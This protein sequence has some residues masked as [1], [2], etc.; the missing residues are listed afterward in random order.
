MDEAYRRAA[1]AVVRGYNDNTMAGERSADVGIGVARATEAVAENY[2][3]PAFRCC[4]RLEDVGVGVYGYR[5]VV[6]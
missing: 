6:E 1:V 5:C 4:R 2:D 3:R